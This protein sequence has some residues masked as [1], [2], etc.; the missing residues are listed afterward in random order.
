MVVG[1]T[2]IF[3]HHAYSVR[4]YSNSRSRHSAFKILLKL[5]GIPVVPVTVMVDINRADRVLSQTLLDG[6]VHH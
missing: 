6:V 5:S 2:P 3:E 4:V 1:L